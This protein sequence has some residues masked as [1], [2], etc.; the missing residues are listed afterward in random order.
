MKRLIQLCA[1]PDSDR[2]S[3][4]ENA[5][6]PPGRWACICIAAGLQIVLN[7]ISMLGCAYTLFAAIQSVRW[8]GG[9]NLSQT[10]AASGRDSHVVRA[11]RRRF[12]AH[13]VLCQNANVS[14]SERSH[15]LV[16]LLCG[17]PAGCDSH[18]YCDGHGDDG[19]EPG[20]GTVTGFRPARFLACQ[21]AD[22]SDVV[23]VAEIAHLN[24]DGLRVM[25][26]MVP[27]VII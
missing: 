17:V 4:G 27:T 7:L 8:H 13:P 9:E 26:R 20:E 24:R 16:T 10:G 25:Q 3:V 21:R 19:N 6:D 5:T 15:P 23:V 18:S 1:L 11:S 12:T 2:P 14:S 22:G